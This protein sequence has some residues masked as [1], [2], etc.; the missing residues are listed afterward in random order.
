MGFLLCGMMISRSGIF[1]MDQKWPKKKVLDA[2]NAA[3]PSTLIG[4][5]K[6]LLQML[7]I[8]FCDYRAQ[9][10]VWQVET[11]TIVFKL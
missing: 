8:L 7:C 1:L 10:R 11:Q 2:S 3:C 9:A 5:M 4:G 6:I